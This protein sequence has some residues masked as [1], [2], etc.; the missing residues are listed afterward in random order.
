MSGLALDS[1]V[2]AFNCG[3]CVAGKMRR[4]PFPLSETRAAGVLDLVHSDLMQVS[5]KSLGGANYILT[6]LDGF[7]D[8]CGFSS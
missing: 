8:F 7:R 4:L 5:Q 2:S 3:P 1:N 6:F